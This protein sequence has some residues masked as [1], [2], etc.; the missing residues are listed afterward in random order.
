MTARR[1]DLDHLLNQ[2][3]VKL[4]GASDAGI[5]HELYDV[6]DEFFKITSAWKEDEILQIIPNTQTYPLNPGKGG[7]IIRLYSVLDA[8]LIQQP[9]ILG[10]PG[11]IPNPP[12]NTASQQYPITNE[13]TFSQIIF[14]IPYTTAQ[15]FVVTVIKS[16]VQPTDK[17]HIPEIPDW[18]IP[19]F[20]LTLTDGLLGKMMGHPKKSYSNDSLSVYHL[21]RFRDEMAMDRVQIMRGNT[22]GL[23]KWIYP[24]GW[25]TRTQR[26]GVSVGSDVGFGF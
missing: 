21:K 19:R 18:V 23:Q 11:L 6:L 3:R 25:R 8:D 12:G 14:R 15:Q 4:P 26:G 16:V 7:Q 5:K 17:N 9:A 13:V 22:Q 24:Q 1:A 10:G 2:A 20:G